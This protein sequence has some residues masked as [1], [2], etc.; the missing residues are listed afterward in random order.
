MTKQVEMRERLFAV[1]EPTIRID[2]LDAHP[3]NPRLELREDVIA[4][5]QA[6]IHQHGYQEMHA[7]IARRLG[8]RYQ[9]LD[10]HHRVDAASREGL[11][12][13]PAWVG[14]YTDEEA[15]MQLALANAQSGLTPLE[16]GRH[17]FQATT[18]Y[19]ANGGRSIA[20]YAEERGHAKEDTV[21]EQIWA[22]E[23][24]DESRNVPGLEKKFIHLVIIH[25]APREHW[26]ELAER[27]VDEGWTVELT[28]A[29][30]KK[31][32]PPK[33]PKIKPKPL[34]TK[35]TLF[36]WKEMSKEQRIDVMNWRE[37]F[38]THLFEEEQRVEEYARQRH[39]PLTGCGHNCP[40]CYARDIAEKTYDEGFEPT[41][42]MDRLNAPYTMPVPAIAAT[43]LSYRNVSMCSMSDLF[44]DWVP[45]EW[46][47][48]VL[49]TVRENPQWNFLFLTRFPIRMAEFGEYPDNA[50]MGTSVDWQVRI[51]NAE[52]AMRKVRA[53][54]KWLAAEPL[55]EPL[56]FEDL[57]VFQWIVIGGASPTASST[58]PTPEW[59]PPRRWVWDLTEQG[60]DA[61]C[62]VYHKKTLNNERIK[63]FPGDPKPLQVEPTAAP[64]VFQYLKVIE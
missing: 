34:V 33:L 64:P 26:G 46:I 21:R 7:I 62:K 14:E 1:L 52:R 61:K 19:G 42:H 9:I 16:L 48:A 23:V 50:W 6:Q 43:D 59:K 2:L 25:R 38:G 51:A 39:D 3:D 24:F 49:E 57:S 28:K 58:G 12:T 11:K 41:L 44:G 15:F 13:I 36:Q 8:K 55:L 40:Y 29:A 37:R 30:V 54:V 56:R 45:T 10:G 22:W 63:Q 31:L 17:A 35:V 32:Q 53:K 4:S 5:I 60:W 27:M 20:K 47:N 18:K